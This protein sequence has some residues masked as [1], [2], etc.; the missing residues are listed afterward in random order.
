MNHV[1]NLR[2]ILSMQPERENRHVRIHTHMHRHVH[3][4]I[5]THIL[6]FSFKMVVAILV[7]FW[8]QQFLLLL[9]YFLSLKLFPRVYNVLRTFVC[10]ALAIQAI[11]SLETAPHSLLLPGL[12]STSSPLCTA[13]SP[14]R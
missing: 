7:K 8:V 2:T 3:A 1:I 4:H 10:C 14:S 9:S 12:H 6:F 13:S 5:H 11:L